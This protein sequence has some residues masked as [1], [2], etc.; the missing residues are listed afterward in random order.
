MSQEKEESK[1][2]FTGLCNVAYSKIVNCKRDRLPIEF[3]I[4]IREDVY[5]NIMNNFIGAVSH[6]MYEFCQKQTI[7]GRPVF[8]IRESS[9]PRPPAWVM[10]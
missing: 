6:E 1:A 2:Y 8:V 4:Y 10:A 5:N 9:N 3:S 7:L